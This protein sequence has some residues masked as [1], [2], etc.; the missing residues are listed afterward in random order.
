MFRLKEVRQECGLKRSTVAKELKMNA[1]T[2]AN[3]ENEIRQAPYEMLI[4]FADYFDVSVDYL[5]GRSEGEKPAVANALTAEET[6]LMKL[7]RLLGKT[8]KSRVLEYAE[9]WAEGK[10]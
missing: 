5:L 3:Y 1:G 2:I 7:F 8:G 4:K 6:E 9:L 10:N